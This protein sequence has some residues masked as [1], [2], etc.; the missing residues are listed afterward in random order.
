MMDQFDN[1]YDLSGKTAL[2]TGSRKGIGFAIARTLAQA[3]ANVIVNGTASPEAAQSAVAGLQESADGGD[4]WYC[5]SDLTKPGAAKALFEQAIGLTGQIDI[6]VSNASVQRFTPFTEVTEEDIDYQYA[7]NFKAAFVLI[8]LVLKG[9]R[10]RRWGRV[11]TI[12]SVQEETY[13]DKFAAYG[14]LKAAQAHLVKS[15]A[16]AYSGEG[17]TFNNIAPGVINTV[18]NEDFLADSEAKEEMLS[19]IPIG[20][21]GRPEDCSGA[22][23]LLCSQAGEYITGANIFVEGGLRL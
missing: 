13:N 20:R 16:K 22:A 1:A 21:I 7:A 8:Q 17:I 18:R 10:E 19:R 9:M 15:L 5:Q 3:G 11:V 6:L 4:A 12:G 14:A 23:L 2:I